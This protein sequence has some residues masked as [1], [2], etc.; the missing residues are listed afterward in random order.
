MM[1]WILGIIISLFT[2]V[3]ACLFPDKVE[4][5]YPM[6]MEKLNRSGEFM[7][8][9]NALIKDYGEFMVSVS[10][11][12]IRISCTRRYF[13]CMSNETFRSLLDEMEDYG[14]FDLSKDDKDTIASLFEMNVII[15]KLDRK[16]MLK[17]R[18]K[19]FIMRFIG[20]F[21]CVN[22]EKLRIC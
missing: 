16:D 12:G 11:G 9:N 2:L 18:I 8:V 5:W 7:L 3:N 13:D 10:K 4:L 20:K 6:D 19:E 22:Y 21:F 15:R 17:V 14:A 1:R